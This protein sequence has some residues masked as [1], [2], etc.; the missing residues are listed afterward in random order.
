MYA[1]NLATF[2]PHLIKEGAL[3]LDREDEIIRETLV[4][5]G[6]EVVNPRARAS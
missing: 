3:A 2:I 5:E 1:R 6:G 4:T